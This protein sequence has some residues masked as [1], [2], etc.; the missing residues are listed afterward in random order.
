MARERP[1]YGNLTI[2]YPNA[3]NV[4]GCGGFQ[5]YGKRQYAGSRLAAS[6][7]DET[8]TWPG[9][10]A[11]PPGGEDWAFNFSGLPTNVDLL[12]TVTETYQGTGGLQ[13]KG[14]MSICP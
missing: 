5:A 1:D 4:P 9:T 12:L 7:T 13:S 11:K 6:V 2:D 8:H 10:P 3:Y 14:F